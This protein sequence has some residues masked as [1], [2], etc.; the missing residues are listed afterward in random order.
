MM[1]INAS[2][3]PW[4]MQKALSEVKTQTTWICSVKNYSVSCLERKINMM[5]K[6]SWRKS[7][8]LSRPCLKLFLDRPLGLLRQGYKTM[9]QAL[10]TKCS[11]SKLS[12]APLLPLQTSRQTR[13]RKSK[14]KLS[15]YWNNYK[16]TMSS[17]RRSLKHRWSSQEGSLE[18]LNRHRSAR[19]TRICSTP[20][21]AISSTLV[22]SL[23]KT[24]AMLP[25]SQLS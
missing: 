21:L 14:N 6:N 10:E 17:F 25:D 13:A 24:I 8:K 2:R 22:Y 23:S 1:I 4:I 11:C 20:W 12:E 7:T 18:D 19:G 16:Q 3:L 9:K 5:R 15:P